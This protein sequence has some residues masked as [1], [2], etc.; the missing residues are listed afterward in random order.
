MARSSFKEP[1]FLHDSLCHK[2]LVDE[3]E[4]KV[5]YSNLPSAIRPV[6]HFNILPVPITP[7]NYNIEKSDSEDKHQ[8]SEEENPIIAGSF[9]DPDFVVDDLGEPHRLNQSELSDP[10]RNLDLLKEKAELLTSRLL[11]LLQPDIKVTKYRNQ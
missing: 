6:P 11:H 7:K 10:I 2:W 1:L 3:K 5:E 4:K 8:G 9:H